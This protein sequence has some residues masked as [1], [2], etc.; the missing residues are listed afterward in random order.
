MTREHPQSD[1]NTNRTG[2]FLDAL[3]NIIADLNDHPKLQRIFG[4]PV[5][6]CLAIIAD[7]NDLRIED[8]GRVRLDDRQATEFLAVL[9]EIIRANSV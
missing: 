1:T 5:S 2:I 7:D 4:T 8:A 3:D 6:R 9:D